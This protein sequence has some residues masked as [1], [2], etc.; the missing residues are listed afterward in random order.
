MCFVYGLNPSS[1]KVHKLLV[2]VCVCVLG[3]ATLSFSI[4]SMLISLAHTSKLVNVSTI[5]PEISLD[6]V[7]LFRLLIPSAFYFYGSNQFFYI[8]VFVSLFCFPAW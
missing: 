6:G 4:A 5:V 1:S 3:V 2:C 8:C 7:L